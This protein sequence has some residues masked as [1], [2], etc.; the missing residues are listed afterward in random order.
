MHSLTLN[1]PEIIDQ[2]KMKLKK[3]DDIQTVALVGVGG[4]GK[5]TI[6]RQYACKQKV[7]Y[8]WEI[9]AETKESLKASF[10]NIAKKLANTEEYQKTLREIQALK[11]PA[12]KEEAIIHFVKS[13]LKAKKKWLLIYDNVETFTDIQKYFPYDSETWGNGKVI[14]TTR[15]SNID[16]N[17]NL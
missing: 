13:R 16:N 12:E 6:A 15:D 14:I 7:S 3:Q 1:R 9:N 2:I 10:E 8:L 5:T 4:A 17:N 11:D